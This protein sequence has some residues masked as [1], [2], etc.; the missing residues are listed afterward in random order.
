MFIEQA[1][2]KVTKAPENA[3]YEVRLVKSSDTSQPLS[4]WKSATY[5]DG[6]KILTVSA[7]ETTYR[8]P[9]EV[10]YTPSFKT[11]W[12]IR[13]NGVDPKKDG[14]TSTDNPV[15]G[16]LTGPIGQ[17][18]PKLFRSVVH[19]ACSVDGAANKEAALTN[20]WSQLS[21]TNPDGSVSPKNFKG[22]DDSTSAW[23]RKLYYYKKDSTW[24]ICNGGNSAQ[25]LQSAD[26]RCFAWCWLMYDAI[27]LNGYNN[28]SVKGIEVVLNAASG[29]GT[30]FLVKDFEV[31]IGGEW[32]LDQPWETATK[33][34]RFGAYVAPG[35]PDMVPEPPGG[36][37]GQFK[38]LAKLKGQN[39]APPSQKVFANHFMVQCVD[40]SGMT[41]NYDPS[42]GAKYPNAADFQEKSLIGFTKD[43]MVNPAA[44]DVEQFTNPNSITFIQQ[45]IPGY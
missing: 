30:A 31:L 18:K 22:W 16:A 42:Y 1:E 38:N 17:D 37:Y 39:S 29:G 43:L 7:I 2:W 15:Y 33:E 40:G 5:D 11:T 13:L 34:F 3:T 28:T 10:S 45:N 21:Q 20:T 25:L 24:A 23:E 8:F 4:D 36:V 44:I 26:G 41:V 19:L 9:G 32:K 6:T 14:G 35:F 27:V 12:Q